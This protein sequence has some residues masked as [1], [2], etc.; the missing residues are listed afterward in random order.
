[1][2]TGMLALMGACLGPPELS[3]LMESCVEVGTD[4]WIGIGTRMAAWM[5][6]SLDDC[7]ESM[8]LNIKP[9]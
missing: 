7:S 6:G 2:A 4:C 3:Q 5:D 9:S 1:M 8:G